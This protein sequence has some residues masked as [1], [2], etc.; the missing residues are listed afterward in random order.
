MKRTT[1][2]M[3]AVA[4]IA[5]VMAVS[6]GNPYI[7]AG[8]GYVNGTMTVVNS[9]AKITGGGT[10]PVIAY[11][12]VLPDEDSATAGTQIWPFASAE[13]TDLYACV[14]VT[15][16]NGRDNVADV[17]IDVYHPQ[18]APLC[19]SQKYQVHGVKMDNTVNRTQIEDCKTKARNAG[20]ITQAEFNDINYNIFNQTLYYMYYVNLRNNYCQPAGQYEARTFAVDQQGGVAINKSANFTWIPSV[21]LQIDF[22]NGVNFGELIPGIEQTVQGDADMST[23]AAPTMKNEGNVP[24]AITLN[25][26]KLIGTQYN[27][28]I[29]NFDSQF[30]SEYK[31]YLALEKMTFSKAQ[32]LCQTDKIDFSVKAPPWNTSG[33]LHRSYNRL[34]CAGSI[35]HA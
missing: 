20:L 12:W 30:R 18:G 34:R 32:Q 4:I 33:Q 24:I 25:N 13:R 17:F 22:Y 16:P 19:G 10:P 8:D 31:Q 2:G 9:A 3:V 15:D 14:V 35:R 27:K 28:E 26:T 23:P 29:V 5:F 1:F 6:A 7:P 21:I 11:T